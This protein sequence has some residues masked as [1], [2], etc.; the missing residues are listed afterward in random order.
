MPLTGTLRMSSTR[1]NRMTRALLVGLLV[2]SLLFVLMLL[3]GETVARNLPWLAA[4][5]APA[6]ALIRWLMEHSAVKD[7]AARF[8]PLGFVRMAQVLGFLVQA[9][10]FSTVAL[11]LM[12]SLDR[13]RRR[14]T[15]SQGTA[16]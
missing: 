2:E 13:Y 14:R 9:A 6:A 15:H 4:L 11:L 8:S 16:M 5:Q 3:F 7:F 12:A 1:T 10:I